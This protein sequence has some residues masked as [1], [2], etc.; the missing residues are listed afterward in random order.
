RRRPPRLTLFP[1]TTLFRS[2]CRI[3]S[4]GLPNR[5]GRI[6]IHRDIEEGVHVRIPAEVKDGRRPFEPKDLA[7][8]NLAVLDVAMD[9]DAP[10]SRS[11]EHTS[12][13]Q[14]RG[15]LVCR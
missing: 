13:L 11:E 10:L 3:D 12:E 8:R 2:P 5:K 9:G 6:A 14:S 7:F 15:H 4:Q 1:Y